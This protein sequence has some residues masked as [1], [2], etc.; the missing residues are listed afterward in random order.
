M[1]IEQHSK[2]IAGFFSKNKRMPSYSEMMVLFGYR[3]KN[4][5]Y[6]IV[7][8]LITAGIV[9][10]DTLGRIV[11]KDIEIFTDSNLKEKLRIIA[12]DMQDGIPMLGLVTAGLPADIDA[13][14]I[15]AMDRINVD[16]LLLGTNSIKRKSSFF[17][18]VDGDSMIDA[19]I[20]DGDMVLVERTQQ[21]KHGDIVIAFIDGEWTM[22][23]LRT[24]NNTSWLEPANKKYKPIY[25]EQQ[26]EIVA[27]VKAVIR[28]Y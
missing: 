16:S 1:G 9:A 25:P 13:V 3:S 24:K 5:V 14:N 19:H 6:R 12:D 20:D 8:K 23:Y 18:T 7:D 26:L 21:A 15:E 22:K 27:V 11:P 10:K 28:K 17:L 2:K 4:A